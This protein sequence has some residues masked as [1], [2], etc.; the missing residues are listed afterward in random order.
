MLGQSGHADSLAGDV[1]EGRRVVGRT[2]DLRNVAWWEFQGS[3]CSNVAMS[4]LDVCRGII[5]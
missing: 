2:L 4:V 5:F 1:I 3:S